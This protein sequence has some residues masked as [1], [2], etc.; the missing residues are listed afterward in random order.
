MILHTE[1]V[2]SGTDTNNLPF[3][4]KKQY[5]FSVLGNEVPHPTNSHTERSATM[6]H[7]NLSPRLQAAPVPRSGRPGER[8]LIDT[9][10]LYIQGQFHVVRQGKVLLHS[11]AAQN[12]EGGGSGNFLSILQNP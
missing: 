2:D 4:Y 3:Q 7:S 11:F 1:P 10:T 6:I 5:A 8:I 9:T 12:L